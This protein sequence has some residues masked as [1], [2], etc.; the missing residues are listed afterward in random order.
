LI[1][2][3]EVTLPVTVLCCADST[4]VMREKRKG[5]K[6]ERRQVR[7]KI[8]HSFLAIDRCSFIRKQFIIA[9]IF[10]LKKFSARHSF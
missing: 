5:N 8:D 10:C 9:I 7:L 2:V 1:V 6:I 4:G 3:P